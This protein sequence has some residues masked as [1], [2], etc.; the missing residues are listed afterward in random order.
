MHGIGLDEARSRARA[1]VR[2][3]RRL[4]RI[5]ARRTAC[6]RDSETAGEE[7]SLSRCL[8]VGA[9]E[10]S[11]HGTAGSPGFRSVSETEARAICPMRCGDQKRSTSILRGN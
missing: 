5:R 8:T 3:D 11:G 2:R 1:H 6:T 10:L 7:S 4:L 9:P